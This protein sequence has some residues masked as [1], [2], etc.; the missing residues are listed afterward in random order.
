MLV[1]IIIRLPR[2]LIYFFGYVTTD[3]LSDMLRGKL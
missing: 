2:I 3:D 1:K